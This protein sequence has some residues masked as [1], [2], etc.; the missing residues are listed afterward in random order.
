[1]SGKLAKGL[2][3]VQRNRTP[4]HLQPIEKILKGKIPLKNF[5]EL[6]A[7]Y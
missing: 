6:L 4:L 2:V 1:L 3:L 7:K 5:D